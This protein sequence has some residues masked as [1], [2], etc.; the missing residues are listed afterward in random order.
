MNNRTESLFKDLEI[1]L[2]FVKN[3]ENIDC[4]IHWENIE[5]K[6]VDRKEQSLSFLREILT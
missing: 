1:P 6:L 2:E 5:K 4:R 3:V